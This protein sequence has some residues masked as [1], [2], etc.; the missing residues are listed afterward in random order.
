MLDGAEDGV[1]RVLEDLLGRA[2][3][4]APVEEGTLRAAGNLEVTRTAGDVEGTISFDTVYAAR[5][6]EETDWVH[7]LGGQAKYLEAPLREQLPRY[8]RIIGASIDRAIT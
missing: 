3:R 6:H 2:Q 1:K 5:Q 4:L 8:E 7:P